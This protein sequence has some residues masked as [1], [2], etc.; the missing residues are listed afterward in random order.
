LINLKFIKLINIK[1]KQ[2]NSLKLNFKSFY[3]NSSNSYDD[4]TDINHNILSFYPTK[5]I[6]S[7]FWNQNKISNRSKFECTMIDKANNYNGKYSGKREKYLMKSR[8]CVKY[9]IHSYTFNS[10]V[11]IKE[12]IKWINC[13]NKLLDLLSITY[14]PNGSKEGFEEIDVTLVNKNIVWIKNL[15]LSNNNNNVKNYK[16]VNLSRY[17]TLYDKCNYI[18]KATFVYHDIDL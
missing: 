9:M 11:D 2:M 17:N 12:Y 16:N 8:E 7:L 5:F 15:S 13:N 6:I 4:M 1:N 3:K 10:I 14:L 18:C